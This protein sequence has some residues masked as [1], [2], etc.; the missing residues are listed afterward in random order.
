MSG[1]DRRLFMKGAAAGALAC[2]I[3]GGPILV[4]TK[5]VRAEASVPR[6]PWP[7]R[8]LLDVVGVE[9]PIIQA[10]MG[11]HVGSEMA[12]AVLTAGG[13]GSLPCAPLTPKQVREEVAKIRAQVHKPINLNF[14]C[15][16]PPQPD[17]AR[18]R[19]WQKRL[20][21]YYVELGLDPNAPIPT[22]PARK[23]FDAE[24]CDAVVELKPEV[25]S[26]H[27]GLPDPALL[28]RVKSAG[29]VVLS[30]ATTVT[31]G[32]WLEEHGADAV[33]AQ[34]AEAGGSRAMF[35]TNDVASQVGTF[36]LVEQI[37]DA[38]KVP[39]I[40]AG[41]IADGR[42]IAAVLTLG[43]SGVQMGTAYLLCPESR[44][45]AL[46]RAALK[47]AHS[48]STVITNVFTGR[49]SR[50]IINRLVREQGPLA[51]SVPPFPLAANALQPLRAAAESHGSTDFTPLYSGQAAPLCRE[52]PAS[53]LTSKLAT[54]AIQKLGETNRRSSGAA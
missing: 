34:G 37:V 49:P 29:C 13:L 6:G 19:A 22:A 47:S 40:A 52:L 46:H 3:E 7:N 11:G 28:R 41:G 21:P 33:I 54:E 26:F 31:E 2:M 8:R 51:D 50:T 12:V 23:P 1:V 18:E 24:M 43:A 15:H 38:V 32:R 14:F 48:D 53:E 25:V 20:A 4:T 5:E 44:A 9:H 36:A 45:S 39:V 27:Y 42:G 10:P 35:L 30:S 16:I 17:E